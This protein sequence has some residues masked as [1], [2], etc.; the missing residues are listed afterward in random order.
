MTRR[1]VAPVLLAL[2]AGA[3]TVPA[4]STAKS[5]RTV[6]VKDNR[7]VAKSITVRRGAR[8]RWVW[9]GRAPHN[10]TVVRGPSRFRSSTKQRGSFSRRLNKRG[11][12]FILCTIHAPGMKMKIRV[13]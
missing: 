10:V 8:V 3:L 6:T 12:Y 2:T 11:T 1:T 9:K 7:F 5:P 4:A 13:R